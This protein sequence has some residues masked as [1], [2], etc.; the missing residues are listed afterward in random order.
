MKPG[1]KY[2]HK[3]TGALVKVIK[4]GTGESGKPIVFYRFCKRSE[5]K[6][7][8]RMILNE[9]K[10]QTSPPTNWFLGMFKPV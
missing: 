6:F 1:D 9:P 10:Y 4:L 8:Q 2:K 3:L 7:E 5:D